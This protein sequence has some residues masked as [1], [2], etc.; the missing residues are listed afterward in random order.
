MSRERSSFARRICNLPTVSRS[1]AQVRPVAVPELFNPALS[2][3]GNIGMT[4]GGDFAGHRVYCP[5]TLFTLRKRTY[6]SSQTDRS[7]R[8][9]AS[10]LCG[11]HLRILISTILSKIEALAN[12]FCLHL[13]R[14]AKATCNAFQLVILT[15]RRPTCD[16]E[17]SWRASFSI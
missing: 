8:T 1:Y 2:K 4:F 5:F 12:L 3:L 13:S 9:D 16:E 11:A 17:I 14:L 15:Q 6:G 7:K 10:R